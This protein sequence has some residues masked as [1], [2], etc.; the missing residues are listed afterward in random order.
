MDHGNDPTTVFKDGTLDT[1]GVLV[2]LMSGESIP[3]YLRLAGPWS[4]PVGMSCSDD[5]TGTWTGMKKHVGCVMVS[6]LCPSLQGTVY[7]GP[8]FPRQQ[9]EGM[10]ATCDFPSRDLRLLT[11]APCKV[12]APE[13]WAHVSIALRCIFR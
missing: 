10:E 4:I 3:I 8:G 1:K 5:L 2:Y 11:I 13:T 12:L 7:P 9:G 6:K